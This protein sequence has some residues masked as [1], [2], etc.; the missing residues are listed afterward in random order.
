MEEK[1]LLFPAEEFLL[2]NVGGTMELG[3]TITYQHSG[4]DHRGVGPSMETETSEWK[5]EE[6]RHI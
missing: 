4:Y 5:E 3:K 2:M 6:K 1:G